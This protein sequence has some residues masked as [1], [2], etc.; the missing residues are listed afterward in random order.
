[1]EK[2]SVLSYIL[3]VLYIVLLIHIFELK[4]QAFNLNTFIL[5]F[6]DDN[7]LISQGKCI[8]QLY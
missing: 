1:M 8:I 6:V 4:T 5:S 3:S 7:L 2:D